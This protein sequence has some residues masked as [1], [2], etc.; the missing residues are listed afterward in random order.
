MITRIVREKAFLD[1]CA[2]IEQK[3]KDSCKENA[4][5]IS[6]K[7]LNNITEEADKEDINKILSAKALIAKNSLIDI[8]KKKL[9]QLSQ[10]PSEIDEPTTN[11][12]FK[13][14]YSKPR[15]IPYF[16]RQV[17]G[18]VSAAILITAL[19][20]KAN[21]KW[22]A[23]RE[24]REARK[25]HE[26]NEKLRKIAEE[27]RKEE[28]A[29]KRAAAIARMSPEE[30]EEAEENEKWKALSISERNQ[31]N[32]ALLL[33]EHDQRLA[34]CFKVFLNTKPSGDCLICIEPMTGKICI[35]IAENCMLHPNC[36]R[37]ITEMINTRDEVHGYN[38]QRCPTCRKQIPE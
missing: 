27:K 1:E 35:A 31:K 14:K 13:A 12:S 20:I 26:E 10:D 25:K 3:I 24:Q 28:E 34:R 18:I 33:P 30:R 37:C 8:A 17:P 36:A 29:E 11:F 16:I 19:G 9:I 5:G 32:R 7:I 21:D 38:Q 15:H 4:H 2:L 6:T 22:E 23:T